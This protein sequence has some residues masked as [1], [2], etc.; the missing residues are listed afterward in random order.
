MANYFKQCDCGRY[1]NVVPCYDCLWSENKQLREELRAIKKI[2]HELEKEVYRI[3]S[4]E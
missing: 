4:W 2:N 3:G 1:A